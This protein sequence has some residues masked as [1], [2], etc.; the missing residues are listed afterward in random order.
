MNIDRSL[1]FELLMQFLKEEAQ[2]NGLDD[3]KSLSLVVDLD[4]KSLYILDDEDTRLDE[5]A[6][7]LN[8]DFDGLIEHLMENPEILNLR[9]ESYGLPSSA[10]DREKHIGPS[11]DKS[12]MEPPNP[13]TLKLYEEF[14]LNEYRQNV[15]NKLI[16]PEL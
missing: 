16:D 9:E 15:L 8:T 7:V 4:R 12:N 2:A 5:A 1:L 13:E 3:I 11:W 6:E 10:A 14:V